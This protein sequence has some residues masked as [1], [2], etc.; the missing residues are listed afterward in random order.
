M[1]IF[2]MQLSCTPATGT[3]DTTLIVR[4][5]QEEYLAKQKKL[6]KCFVDIQKAFDRLPINVTKLV[7]GRNSRGIG[8]GSDE[9]MQRFETDSEK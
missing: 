5:L 8:V 1:F 4:S 7:T 9:S 2:Y 3:V 6:H